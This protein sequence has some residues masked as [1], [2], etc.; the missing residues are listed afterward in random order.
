[1]SCAYKLKFKSIQQDASYL[2]KSVYS[3]ENYLTVL[4]MFLIEI[5]R[6]VFA[7]IYYAWL[8]ND[9]RQQSM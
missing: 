5:V 3:H 4:C 8:R 6:L 2:V 1:M 9:I 7:V